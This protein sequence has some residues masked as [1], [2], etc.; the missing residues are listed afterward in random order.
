MVQIKVYGLSD[1]LNPIKAELSNIIHAALIEG[2]QIAPEKRFHRFFPLDKSDFY[3]PSDRS[4]NYLIME[5]SMFDGRSVATKKQLILLLIQKINIKLNISVDDIE[6]TIFE[7]PK[8]N[9]GIRG[10]PGDE[11]KLNYKVE[12]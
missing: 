9:W 8:S 6:I 12:V 11:L 4:D 2:L 7:T 10:L 1:K 3:Y 5:I